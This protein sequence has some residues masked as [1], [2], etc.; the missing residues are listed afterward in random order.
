MLVLKAKLIGIFKSN[1]YT[2]RDTGKTTIGKTKLQ[3]QTV[4]RM[5]DGSD[6]IELLDISIP[7]EKVGSYKSQIG[8][9]VSVDVGIIGKVNYYGI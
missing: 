9:E 4:R 6:K 1:D 7:P 2:D 8:K 3:L 5:K